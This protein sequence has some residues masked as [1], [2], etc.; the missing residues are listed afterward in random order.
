MQPTKVKTSILT[1]TGL[2]EH[3]T[4]FRVEGAKY[5]ADL[6]DGETI[7]IYKENGSWEVSTPSV[8]AMTVFDTRQE[9]LIH[10]A[11]EAMQLAM[12]TD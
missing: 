1:A 12:C 5:V 3:T 2:I 6:A 11:G 4:E 10:A 7:E 9:A 8:G